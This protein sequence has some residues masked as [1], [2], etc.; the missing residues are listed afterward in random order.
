MIEIEEKKF[1]E[2]IIS[3]FKLVSENFIAHFIRYLFNHSTPLEI[4]NI[5]FKSRYFKDKFQKKSTFCCCLLK[6]LVFGVYIDF[7]KV[8]SKV[9]WAA[10]RPDN[11]A[12]YSWPT[13]F[14]SPSQ[15]IDNLPTRRL[16]YLDSAQIEGPLRYFYLSSSLN[17]HFLKS[18]CLQ[19][20]NQQ[21]Y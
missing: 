10:L 12:I 15:A 16:S 18:F 7:I 13:R 19:Q 3:R 21:Y 6:V 5:C 4:E 1:W 9:I 2:L 17:Y 20:L 14:Y 8:N 11:R